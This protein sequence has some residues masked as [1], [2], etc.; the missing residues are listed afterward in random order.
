M[1]DE[2]SESSVNKHSQ[3]IR[4]NHALFQEERGMTDDKGISVYLGAHL[5]SLQKEAE[6]FVTL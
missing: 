2:T 3:V 1:R 5:F 4:N 6:L